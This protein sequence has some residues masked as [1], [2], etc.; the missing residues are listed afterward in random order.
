MFKVRRAFYFERKPLQRQ[1]FPEQNVVERLFK[2]QTLQR[3]FAFIDNAVFDGQL[4]PIT[5]FSYAEQLRSGV[6]AQTRHNRKT[7][8]CEI[9]ISKEYITDFDR[10][11]SALMH[12]MCHCAQRALSHDSGSIS[13]GKIWDK[14]RK[15]CCTK[16]PGIPI[17]PYHKW[18]IKSQ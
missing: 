13:H 10:L 15:K 3:L 9:L 2:F 11:M 4:A 14:W 16:F 17:E 6:A 12:E 7:H 1:R 18:Q 8:K 5:T